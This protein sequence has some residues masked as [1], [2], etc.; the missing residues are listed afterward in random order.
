MGDRIIYSAQVL[1]LKMLKRYIVCQ[2]WNRNVRA[3]I[4]Y[5]ATGILGIMGIFQPQG[6]KPTGLRAWHSMC[7]GPESEPGGHQPSVTASLDCHDTR[8]HSVAMNCNVNPIINHP[9]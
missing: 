3:D 8:L 6:M 9:Q 7:H 1:T 4:K 5:L 2:Q